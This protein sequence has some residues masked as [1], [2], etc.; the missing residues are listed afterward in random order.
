[1]VIPH[2]AR[3][4][5]R[6]GSFTPAGVHS[7]P[8]T[9]GP[10]RL[11]A[12]YANLPLVHNGAA[13]RLTLEPGFADEE[14]T[15]DVT[16][17]DAVLTASTEAGLLAGVQTVRQL[18]PRLE[19]LA[20]RD[21]PRLPWRGVLLDVA[22]HFL[23]L[24]FLR[25]FVDLLALHKYNVLH[26]HLTDDQGW[27]IEIDGW[28]RLTEIGAW[29]A[30]SMVGAAGSGVFDGLPHGGFYTQRELR[31]LVAF[32]AARGVRIVPEID[33]PGHVRAAL[34]AYPELG[35]R[36]DVRLPVWTEWGI[37][38]DILGVHDG[39]FAFCRDVLT[40]VADVFPAPYLHIGGDECPTT[41]WETS[42]VARAKAAALG[43]RT[44]AELHPWFLGELH[45]V[46]AGLGRQAVCWDET[47]HAVGGLPA[48]LVVTAWRDAAHGALAVARGHQVVMAPHTST[49]F[50]YRQTEEPGEPPR[51]PVTTLEDV[52]RFDPLAGGLPVSDGTRP[53]VLGT[54]AQLWTEHAPTPDHVRH[55]A[56]PRL[57]ALAERAWS[58]PGRGYADFHQRLAGHLT[59][60]RALGALPKER[61]RFAGAIPVPEKTLP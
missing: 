41:H 1:M 21:A 16:P 11:L 45:A 40:Q 5:R 33:L 51:E 60:L 19:C 39:A 22:R 2:P 10:A 15:L 13:V 49:Y 56:F 46:V 24:D 3:L 31:E 44:T 4:T 54:Q 7:G 47:G 58:P 9:D 12:A 29:R 14:Y 32:A 6:A 61:V 34:A 59:R 36:P 57:C 50:D 23:P 38:P 20:I 28:P 53:G 52:Y 26:L 55:L 18:L 17:E 42:P 30:E 27:R 25:E 8:G 48:D 37:S 35:N 43:L